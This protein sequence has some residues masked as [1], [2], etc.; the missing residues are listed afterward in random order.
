MPHTVEVPEAAGSHLL[1]RASQTNEHADCNLRGIARSYPDLL[2]ELGYQLRERQTHIGGAIGTAAHVAAQWVHENND[3]RSVAHE[4]GIEALK[5]EAEPGVIWDQTTRTLDEAKVQVQ[6]ISAAYQS[7]IYP[8]MREAVVEKRLW[9]HFPELKVSVSGQPDAAPIDE[10]AD[11]K[12]AAQA[13][14]YVFQFGTYG[15]L[16]RKAGYLVKK[17]REIR[18]PRTPVK[19]G[20]KAPV[21]SY[22]DVDIAQRLAIGT[23][24]DIRKTV[25]KVRRDKSIESVA[26]NPS[27]ILCTDRYCPLYGRGCGAE[28]P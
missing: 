22:Y 12:T 27:S 15:I 20:Q 13:H 17:L 9:A 1:I 19:A 10:V 14:S 23:I 11:L 3:Q 26:R 8:T 5:L 16:R 7:S 25:N 6:R 24:D 2:R 18:I 28:R 21:I 4:V